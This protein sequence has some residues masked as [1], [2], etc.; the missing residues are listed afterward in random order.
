MESTRTRTNRLPTGGLITAV[1][2]GSL[3][4]A[5][6]CSMGDRLLA[7]NGQALQDLIDYRFAIT[8]RDVTLTLLRD[9][10]EVLVAIAKEEDQDLGLAFDEAVF[11][12][13]RQCANTCEFCFIHQMPEGQFRN[14]L[15]I[16]DDDYRL[17][18]LQGNFITMTN[19][20]ERDWKRIEHLR[21]SPLYISV[22]TTDPVLRKAMLKQ[23]LAER[24]HAQL[25][26]LRDMGIDFHAQIVLVRDRNDGEC[27]ERT[28]EDLAT[29]WGVGLLSINIVPFGATRFRETLALPGL[30]ATT[31]AWC[32]DVIRQVRPF[33]RRFRAERGDDLVRLADEFYILAD[34]A[35]PG[36]RHYGDYTNLGDGVGGCRLLINEWN[37]VARSLPE[38]IH[39]ARHV[40]M[41]TGPAAVR[42]MQPIVACLNAVEGLEVQLL[43]I[44]SRTWGPSIT[45]TGL[46]T[47]EDLIAGLKD[48]AV[49]GEV[50]L[51]DIMLR[52]GSR[53][54]LDDLTV[55]DI[56]AAASVDI[57]VL[58]TDARGLFVA[59]TD[60][61]A[62]A[63][64]DADR[65]FGSY[66]R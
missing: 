40:T 49:T 27:L 52:P 29:R 6:G 8:E 36:E 51:P 38:R 15:Y 48:A 62:L 39:P 5:A 59:A 35:F 33:Q 31:P 10:Q 18:F 12:R 32:R 30:A 25:D 54:L 42:V 41:L 45:V 20:A 16:E 28:L 46:R 56:A 14:S 17:S 63:G 9:D 3:A 19:L 50:W 37:R 7:V 44:A 23:P 66:Y 43:P 58:P 11:D 1:A 13:I 53:T 55:E 21:L 65:W 26:R 2:P 34:R 61:V 57:K 22:H 60:P 64:L 24:L 47:G 4:A